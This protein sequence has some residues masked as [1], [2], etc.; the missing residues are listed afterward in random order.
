MLK[1]GLQYIQVVHKRNIQLASFHT[2]GNR[3]GETKSKVSKLN[4]WG[5]FSIPVGSMVLLKGS[6]THLTAPAGGVV[7]AV[8]C[9]VFQ[10]WRGGVA[11][12]LQA[13]VLHIY[14]CASGSG[15]R[16]G[17]GAPL[18][19]VLARALRG[20]GSHVEVP[21]PSGGRS[22]PPA[23]SAEHPPLGDT[24]QRRTPSE[25]GTGSGPL[26]W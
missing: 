19:G 13:R 10:M 26:V 20:S 4:K 14:M 6:R 7:V 2:Y 17:P 9:T 11:W 5:G 25:Q 18:G 22:G 3:V 8:R 24:W 1:V 16:G 23:D 15:A 21:D 12:A